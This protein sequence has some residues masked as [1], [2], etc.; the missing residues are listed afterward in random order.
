MN[1]FL[2]LQKLGENYLKLYDDNRR[3][4]NTTA[5]GVPFM[6]K[7][8]VACCLEGEVVFVLNNRINALKAFDSIKELC[9]AEVV[10]FPAKDD[11]LLYK[12]AVSYQNT[13]QR[14][15]ALFKI[16]TGQSRIMITTINALMQPVPFKQDMVKSLIFEKNQTFDINDLSLKLVELGYKRVD[17][18]KSYGEFAIRGS[19]LDVFSLNYEHP[20]R[21]DFWGDE[22]DSVKFFEL[23]TQRTIKEI[24]KATVCVATDIFLE[25]T[26]IKDILY[27]MRKSANAIKDEKAKRRSFEIIDDLT[28]SLNGGCV[29]FT[30]TWLSSFAPSF[31]N[32]ALTYFNSPTV[33]FDEPKQILDTVEMAYKE[34]KM[35]FDS[36]CV[37]GET[38]KEHVNQILNH[39]KLF[40][41]FPNKKKLS[42]QSILTANRLFN[43]E[44][45]ISFKETTVTN[46]FNKY[47]ELIEDLLNWSR[48]DYTVILCVPDTEW[49]DKFINMLTENGIKAIY[50]DFDSV[51]NG[52]NV[53]VKALTEGFIFHSPRLVVL[54][55][56]NIIRQKSK[57]LAKK[58]KTDVF[59]DVS[60]GDLVVHTI[61]GIGIC[62][63]IKKIET[64]GVT[65]DYVVTEYY[66]GDILYVPLDQMDDLNKYSGSETTKLSRLG[67]GEFERIKAK[68]REQVK[69]M[70]LD[71]FK[72]YSE[73]KNTKGF[74]F[75]VDNGLQRE[76]E[77]AFP[78]EETPDQIRSVEEIKNDMQSDKI[79]DRL[80]CGDVGYGKTEVALR[81][82]FKAV[83][84]G[85]QV[86]FL[87][88]TTILS[89]QHY[90]TMLSRFDQFGVRVEV[91]N[92]FK[93]AKEIKVILE[94]LKQ[95][96]VDVICGTHRVLSND[97]VFKDL[98][99][100]VIDE[101]QRFGVVH[102]EKIKSIKNNV[103]VLSMSA[104]PIPR[105][106]HMSLSGIRD[107]SVIETPPLK[108]LPVVTSVIE[109]TDGVITDSILREVNRGGQVFLLYN[110]IETIDSFAEKVRRMTNVEV[111]VAHS[112]M[113]DKL[114]E[115]TIM[116]FYSGSFSVLCSTTIIENGIDLPNANTL[117]VIDADKMGLSQLY[118][119]RGRV[120]R[121]DKLAYA[122]FLF[123]E[124]KVLSETSYKRL[125]AITEFTEF[126]S[127]FKIAMKDL[128]IRGAGDVLGSKQ[129]GWTDKV[130]YDMY[131]KLVNECTAELKGEVKNHVQ[132]DIEV[133]IDSFVPDVYI[134][135]EKE[136]ITLYQQMA[137]VVDD[138]ERVEMLAS[139]TDIYGEPPESVN[140][141]MLISIVK[142]LA[143]RIGIVKVVINSKQTYFEFENV[144]YLADS[145]VLGVLNKF[146][147]E[148]SI[149][150]E[151][152]P[153]VKIE[154]KKLSCLQKL[155]VI[156]EIFLKCKWNIQKS[157][158]F[159]NKVMYNK[160]VSKI[161]WL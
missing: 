118:Q 145:G 44:S 16:A 18:V 33:I 126:G 113:D 140:N 83:L 51:S 136:R 144:K 39:G 137:K 77:D 125:Q 121:S 85:K 70:V 4:L 153:T 47:E 15:D 19:I 66:G 72:L 21:V 17:L 104:T 107:I 81:A 132:T 147:G 111:R 14:I 2:S 156:K 28:I 38:L 161:M 152:K 109:Q 58:N 93:T 29:D 68:V 30:N 23:E 138:N 24:D 49:Q 57:T 115:S 22:V 61:H 78:F 41:S 143:G 8:V 45:V 154:L 13:M 95:G 84:D 92:R 7:C 89:Q 99:L 91:L 46:Y 146:R 69:E 158:D 102:K 112:R 100:L 75:S 130:G 71:L 50:S 73:R 139:L 122:Y 106:L 36:L 79:M 25:E 11:V 20:I 90:N 134:N 119:L 135:N 131:M 37:S 133:E 110:K 87:A 27:K 35:R 64:G 127:G 55:N 141:I 1:S 42:F 148:Y 160:L 6:N 120:G 86:C 52:I 129:H 155:A 124:N 26:E 74:K 88:P 54:G 150:G 67:G 149:S 3:G 108:R 12:K 159:I 62:R 157:I 116:D 40:E 31:D 114:M 32:S 142:N 151:L 43:P 48:N 5:F 65:K 53:C 117:I 98:G 97:V 34:H 103:D 80:L 60:P 59:F 63:G 105:T 123:K 96:K 56:K 76:F 94:R 9:G 101:E 10:F 82:V 128:E